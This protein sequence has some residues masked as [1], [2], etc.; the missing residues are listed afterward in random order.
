[1]PIPNGTNSQ[2]L[3][4]S[5]QFTNAGLYSV[6]VSNPFGS[7][8]NAPAQV[9]VNPAGVSLGIYPG[10]T[11]TG[12]IGYIYTIQRTPDLANTNS[13]V[14]LTNLT[15]SQPVQIWV[16]TSADASKPGNPRYFYRVLPGQ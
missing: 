16:D 15:L 7:V 5:I 10:V 12:T 9:V 6:V 14:T 4:S 8:T 1:M 13:W 3:L 2:L 11:I